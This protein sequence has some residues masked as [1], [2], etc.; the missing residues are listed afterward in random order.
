MRRIVN[1]FGQFVESYG[2]DED[3]PQAYVNADRQAARTE[4]KAF[5]EKT[6]RQ[7]RAERVDDLVARI[8]QR[9]TAATTSDLGEA[10]GL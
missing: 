10:A 9:R 5:V 4:R 6:R 3:I 1:R 2:P 8:E 7:A